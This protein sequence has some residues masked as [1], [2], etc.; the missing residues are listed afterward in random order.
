MAVDTDAVFP[1]RRIC[2]SPNNA[3]DAPE[4]AMDEII[5]PDNPHLGMQRSQQRAVVQHPKPPFIRSLDQS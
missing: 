1:E 5:V 2:D 3:S 4:H